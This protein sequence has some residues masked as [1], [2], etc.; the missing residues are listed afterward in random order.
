MSKGK[1]G[2][3]KENARSAV[4]RIEAKIVRVHNLAADRR[5]KL[6]ALVELWEKTIALVDEDEQP[7]LLARFEEIFAEELEDFTPPKPE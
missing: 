6:V 1:K 7:P 3:S 2:L 4:T 5:D